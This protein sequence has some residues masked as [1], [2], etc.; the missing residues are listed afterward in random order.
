MIK[1]PRILATVAS[2]TEHEPEPFT[3]SR[4]R[5]PQ[6]AVVEAVLEGAI[7]HV[8]GIHQRRLVVQDGAL[9]GVLS[10]D[11]TAPD[12][13][14]T[15]AVKIGVTPKRLSMPFFL[16][17]SFGPTPDLVVQ[18]EVQLLQDHGQPPV[19]PRAG[20]G[21]VEEARGDEP[22]GDL[23]ARRG[24]REDLHLGAAVADGQVEGVLLD[25]RPI[26]KAPA[27]IHAPQVEGWVPF[28]TASERGSLFL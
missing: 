19:A 12:L 15:A 11:E 17:V 6:D 24:R 21:V 14:S 28:P 5:I 1:I 10:H 25:V 4:I 7:R 3:A 2:F 18:R 16:V 8:E 26:L 27:G 20:G 23:G 9:H 22:V 13:H